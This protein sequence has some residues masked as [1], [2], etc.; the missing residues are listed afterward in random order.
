M[1]GKAIVRSFVAT[2]IV[3]Y[4][5]V[6]QA[7]VIDLVPVG[8]PGNP[9]DGTGYGSVA[10]AY[11]IG[12]YEV[13][14]GQYTEFLNAKAQSDPNGLYNPAMLSSV[15][16]CKIQQTGSS[17]SFVYSVAVDYAD[18]PV[19]YVSFWDAARFSNWLH[20]GQGNGDTESG[21]YIHMGLSTFAR[22]PGAKYFIPTENEWYKAAYHKNDGVTGNYF[23]YPTSSDSVPGRD[24]TESTNQGNNANYRGDPYP[25]DAPYYSTLMGEFEDSDSP[26]GTFDQGGNMAELNETAYGS[27]RGQR[28]GAY[29]SSSVD[30]LLASTSGDISP[31][32]EAYAIGFR[33]ASVVPEPGSFVMLAGFTLMGLLC[34][35][36]RKR[37]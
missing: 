32:V 2:A 22:Q 25:I 9:N 3:S 10:E 13:T 23:D 28:G 31:T 19:N 8:N 26:Y 14:A 12:K 16:G 6:A 30:L 20:N 36:W 21:A 35:A 4:A 15:R 1:L 7:M 18:R 24:M 17:G 33:V 11:L 5:V 34:Y 27:S 29:S 37:R